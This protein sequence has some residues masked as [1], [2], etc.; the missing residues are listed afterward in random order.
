MLTAE[1]N[2]WQSDR[3]KNN[4]KADWRF[5]TD[6]ARIKLKELYPVI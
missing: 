2:A 6:N 4:T 3:N 5:T 1:I